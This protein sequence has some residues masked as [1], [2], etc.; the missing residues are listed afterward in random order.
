MGSTV[1]R[2][3][4]VVLSLVV[5][6]QGASAHPH[7]WVD[8]GVGLLYKETKPAAVQGLTVEMTWDE[9]FS[10]L[11]LADFPLM[12]KNQLSGADLQQLDQVYGLHSP[13]H[14]IRI[15]LTYQGKAV[16]STA[17][18]R[19][20]RV[21]G[22]QVTLV[23]FFPLALPVTSPSEFRVSVYDP[24]YYVDMGIRAKTGAF[25]VG[26]KDP[27]AYEGSYSY[28][29]DFSHPYF[30]GIVFPEVVAFGLKP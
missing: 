14:V 25:Y 24:T 18:I 1:F 27:S 6:L 10:A 28:E 2:R 20:P 5:V 7:E 17:V 29:Q 23:Y 19:A 12:A 8:W 26:V 16:T 4:F 15:D 21:S 13:G 30:G 3:A 9:W 11:M 22:K